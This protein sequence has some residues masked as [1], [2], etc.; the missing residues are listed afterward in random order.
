MAKLEDLKENASVRGILPDAPVTVVKVQWH[1]SEALTLTYRDL[2]GR[3]ALVQSW[4]E[5]AR[6]AQGATAPAQ[7]DLGL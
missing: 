6:L 1:G 7:A 4:P 5:I 2:A 3:P